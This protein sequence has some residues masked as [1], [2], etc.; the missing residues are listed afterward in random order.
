MQE[1]I[2]RLRQIL[3]DI[4]ENMPVVLDIIK[5]LKIDAGILED[6]NKILQDAPA[7]PEFE[8]ID[9]GIGEIDY[10][11]KNLRLQYIMEDLAEI[12]EKEGTEVVASWLSARVRYNNFKS[13]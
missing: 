10:H 2:Q 9:C 13:A 4:G 3:V 7:A 12:I 8:T 11:T 5:E 1:K 6:K